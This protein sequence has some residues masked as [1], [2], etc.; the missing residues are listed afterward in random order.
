[1]ASVNIEPRVRDLG[2][3]PRVRAALADSGYDAV[4]GI[5]VESCQYLS[6][7]W[8]PYARNRLLRQNIVVWPRDGEPVLLCGLDQLPGPTRYSWI[9]D[10]RPYAERGRRPPGVIADLLVATLRDLDLGDATIGIERLFTPVAFFDVLE[11]ELPGVAWADCDVFFDDLRM[12][13]TEQETELITACAQ[14]LEQGLMAGLRLARRGWT[15]KQLANVIRQEILTRGVDDVTTIL[16]GAGDGAR[17]YLTPTDDVIPDGALV[18]IDLNAIQGGYYAD[19]GRMAVM[20]G[21]STVQEE[22]YARQLELNAS[23]ISA[24]RPGVSAASVFAHCQ[25]EAGMLGLELLDQPF[26][27]L[28][29]ATGINNS[30]FPKLNEADMTPLAAGMVLNIEPDTFGPE[31]EI[32]HVEDMLYLGAEGA[33]VITS[34]EDW[35]T[36]PCLG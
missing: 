32:I 21:P 3:V 1:M 17:G 4:I 11:R 26:I 13:K 30:D 16:L 27:G 8:F 29:H 36:L 23:V 33:S 35:S 9:R 34:T 24:V 10:I 25:R 20:H 19:M 15:E 22:A 31:R 14:A 12:I 28:G 6:G 7:Y 5:S 2:I 18:R